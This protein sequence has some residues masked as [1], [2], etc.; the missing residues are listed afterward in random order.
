MASRREK[1]ISPVDAVD[2][3]EQKM[4]PQS[5]NKISPVD[6]V[7]LAEKISPVRGDYTTISILKPV[8]YVE[9]TADKFYRITTSFT[10]EVGIIGFHQESVTLILCLFGYIT[11]GAM[12]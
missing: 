11:L 6:A 8:M 2:L 10:L 9:R 5:E 4:A 3:T 1:T 12:V 7:D